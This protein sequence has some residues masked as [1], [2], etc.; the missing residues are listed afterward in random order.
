[1]STKA[2]QIIGWTLSG[3]ISALLL[4]SAFNKLTGSFNEMM[5]S[6]GFTDSE[7]I[8]IG[9]GEILATVLFLIPK[10]SSLGVLLLSAYMGGAIATHMQAA[11][12]AEN[13]VMP[14]VILVVIWMAAI[15]RVPGV[16]NSFKR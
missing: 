15:L 4:F 14:S 10:T 8:L 6:F 2:K 7:I 11:P 9:I 13:Y 3:L 5:T 1:M 16:L 12:P